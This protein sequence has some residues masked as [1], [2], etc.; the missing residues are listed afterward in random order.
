MAANGSNI[1]FYYICI[2][3]FSLLILN[4]QVFKKLTFSILG[5]KIQHRTRERQVANPETNYNAS[6]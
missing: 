4:D 3:F 2:K 6:G 5:K 1:T